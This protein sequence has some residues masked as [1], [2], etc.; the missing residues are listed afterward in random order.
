MTDQ[1][2]SQWI[3]REET[4]QTRLDPQIAGMLAATLPG[5]QAL[6]GGD[7]LPPLWHWAAFPPQAPTLELGP[8]GHPRTGGFLPATGLPRR[9]WAGGALRF[10]RA[11]HVG[12]RMTR[13]SRIAEVSEKTGGAGRMVFVTVQHEIAGEDGLA[14]EERQDIVYLPMPTEWRAP[15]AV[16]VPEAP[17]LDETVPM[18]A[19]LLFRYSACTF[20]A[21]RIHY[22]LAYAQEVE[23]YPGLV[24]HGPLQATLLM[25]AATRHGGRAPDRFSFRGVHPMFADAPL[26][27]M[28]VAGDAGLTLCTAKGD[29]HQG[30]T[31]TA[32]WEGGV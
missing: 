11:L 28:A 12:E 25:M 23:K 10:H 17:V 2:V 14:I 30:M 31:A 22:D 18:S 15:R 5:A 20:N 1:T 7:T 27:V 19:A 32:S 24:V 21:H 26:R 4:A 13:H 3:G 9:M 8:D 6:S 16:P 29:A